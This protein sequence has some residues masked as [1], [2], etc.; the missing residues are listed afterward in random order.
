M[1]LRGFFRSARPGV[2]W[3]MRLTA[4]L[5]VVALFQRHTQLNNLAKIDFLIRSPR[6]LLN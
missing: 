6:M 5:K 1:A 4:D 2:F 3:V